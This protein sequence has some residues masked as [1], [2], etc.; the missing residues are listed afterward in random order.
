MKSN[1]Y[2]YSGAVTDASSQIA[3]QFE[4]ETNQDGNTSSQLLTRR[5]LSRRWNLSVETLKRW[6]K[7]GKLP[8]FKLGKEIRYRTEAVEQIE[9][10]SEVTK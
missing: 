9:N 10:I 4:K 8:F 1:T 3:S 5:E 6:E 7:S 2:S